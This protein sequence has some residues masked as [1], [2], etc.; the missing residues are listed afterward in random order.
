MSVN[1]E[2]DQDRKNQAYELRLQGKT[3]RAIG[4]A[5][6]IGHGTAERWCKEYMENVKLPLVDEIRKQEVD[7]LL[8]YLSSLDDRIED[9]DD[10]AISLAIKISERLCKMLGAD[11]PTVTVTEHKEVSQLDLDIRSLID[12]QNALNADN[13]SAAARKEIG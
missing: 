6:G 2:A 10:K 4:R 12:A 11:M 1:R 3:Y 9:G 13:K 7:R 5:M 8:R